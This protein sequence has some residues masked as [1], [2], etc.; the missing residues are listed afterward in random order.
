MTRR[1]SARLL[2]AIATLICLGAGTFWLW[3][4]RGYWLADN[5]REVESGRIYAG[6]YQFPIPLARIIDRHHIKT[7]VSLR[8]GD[9]AYDADEREVLQACGVKFV[10]VIIP[11]KV[12]DAERIARVEEAIAAITDRA[13][14]PV[15][16]HCWAGCHRTG[17]VVAIYRVSR[18]GWTEQAARDE[19]VAWGGT[20]LGSQWPTKLLHVY[21][22]RPGAKVASNPE[23][24]SV[25]Q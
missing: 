16:V 21:C 2:I 13:N 12:P 8:E 15:F 9:D 23:E 24:D 4:R 25:R 10:R 19:L 18:C 17:A 7:V 11:Y 6:G 5:F 3:D 1:L 22:T 20:K 14:Q